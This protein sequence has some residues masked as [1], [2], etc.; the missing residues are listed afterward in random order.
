M[1]DTQKGGA[2]R[3][4]HHIGYVTNDLAEAVDVMSRKYA[5]AEITDCGEHPVTLADGRQ[6]LHKTAMVFV[7][8]WGVELIQPTSGAD[9]IYRE[10]LPSR[11]FGLNLH[12]VCFSAKSRAELDAA[13]A[14]FV[15]EGYK[16]AVDSQLTNFFYADTR[17]FFGHYTEW[18]YV[19][20]FE[21]EFLEDIKRYPA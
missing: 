7:E 1:F 16:I 2:F 15:A 10:F 4:F 17:E 21:E 20:P 12:H 11:G 3:G 13:K 9:A 18:A 8:P 14:G 6:Y 5:L 19:G